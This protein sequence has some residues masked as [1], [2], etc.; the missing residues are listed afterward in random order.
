MIVVSY[1]KTRTRDLRL[2]RRCVGRDRNFRWTACGVS[3]MLMPT[4]GALRQNGDPKQEQEWFHDCS[5]FNG[6]LYGKLYHTSGANGKRPLLS[7]LWD[8]V[9]VGIISMASADGCSLKTERNAA[10]TLTLNLP[11]DVQ[12]ALTQDA[13]QQGRTPEQAALLALR[14]AYGASNDGSMI[15]GS[16]IDGSPLGARNALILSLVDS[17]AAKDAAEAEEQRRELALL[18]QG[19]E[20]ARPGQRQVF[21]EGFNP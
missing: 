21:G 4:P 12:D 13:R 2:K 20:E 18:A 15:D 8:S 7:A 3:P 1:Q 17:F 14:R 11:A 10:M 6:L 5:A 9:R 19:I 16:M